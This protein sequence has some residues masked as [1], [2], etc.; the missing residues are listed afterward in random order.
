[1]KLSKIYSNFPDKFK[2]IIFNEGLNVIV[3]EITLIKNKNDKKT[4][5]NLGKSILCRLIDFCLLTSSRDLFLYDHE[6]FKEFSFFLEIQLENKSYITINRN[7]SQSNKISLKKHESS[8]QDYT[9]LAEES[10]DH[11]KIAL[12]KAKNIINTNLLWRISKKYNYRNVIGYFLRSQNDYQNFFNLSKNKGKEVNWKPCLA[13]ILGFD[14]NLIYSHYEKEKLI[15]DK[16]KD[17]KYLEKIGEKSNSSLNEKKA[18]LQNLQKIL[19]KKEQYLNDFDFYKQDQEQIKELVSSIE[20]KIERLNNDCYYLQLKKNK[21]E[22]SLAKKKLTF[23]PNKA[24]QLFKEAEIFF[25]G[26]LKKGYEDLIAFNESIT[27]ERNA[28]LKKELENINLHLEIVEKELKEYNIQKQAKLKFIRNDDVLEKYKEFSRDID[29]DKKEIIN[30][31]NE[32]KKLS[33]A[34]TLSIQIKKLEIEKKDIEI[35]ISDEINSKSYSTFKQ[36]QDYFSQILQSVLAKEAVIS[37]DLNKNSHL[38]FNAKITDSK[39]RLTS[40]DDGHSYKKLMCMAFD[41][42]VLRAHLDDRFAHFVYHDG[43]LESLDNRA[44]KGLLNI[45]RE[46]SVLGIQLII[47]V[48]NSDLPNMDEGF[49]DNEIILKLTDTGKRLFN[50][51]LW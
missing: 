51:S 17:Q 35:K 13:S 38:I 14:G 44:K 32:I 1:M 10:W 21:I 30:L 31:E 26:Q 46:Y 28:Y 39:G 23:D 15:S 22:Q 45:F 43:A 3:G 40:E 18:A 12:E 20:V 25:E 50:M 11:S 8:K 7:V 24:A 36:I 37:V 48:N 4:T 5:H 2:P 6:V 27:K 34:E 41:L 33:E 16:Q 42:A 29:I 49:N 47:T 19:S 9:N